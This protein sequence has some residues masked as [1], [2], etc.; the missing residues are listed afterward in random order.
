MCVLSTDN[1]GMR[2][3]SLTALPQKLDWPASYHNVYLQIATPREGIF[4]L[5]TFMRTNNLK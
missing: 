1:R 5:V 4:T 2:T 3:N